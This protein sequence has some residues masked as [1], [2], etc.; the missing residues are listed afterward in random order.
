MGGYS[1]QFF[2]DPQFSM[3][4]C[5]KCQAK[6]TWDSAGGCKA[7]VRAGRW[8]QLLTLAEGAALRGPLLD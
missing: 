8:T 7:V 3:N 6:E 2:T 1:D 4:M 5:Y